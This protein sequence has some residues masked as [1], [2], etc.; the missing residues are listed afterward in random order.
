MLVQSRGRKDAFHKSHL[1]RG[2]EPRTLS[3]TIFRGSGNSSVSGRERKLRK[4]IPE[5][6]GQQL[7]HS[8][9]TRI[10]IESLLLRPDKLPPK[11]VQACARNAKYRDPILLQLL[12]LE[13]L[14]AVTVVH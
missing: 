9:N 4:A 2:S 5:R 14:I 1:G 12:S 13:H 11:N 8:P 10:K 6:C 7:R 3:T